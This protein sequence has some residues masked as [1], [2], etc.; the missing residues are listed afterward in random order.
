MFAD[1]ISLSRILLAYPLYQAF[2]LNHSFTAWCLMV[3]MIISDLIDGEVSRQYGASTYGKWLDPIADAVAMLAAVMGL[4]HL[5]V[6]SIGWLV[7]WILRYA[8]FAFF[9]LWLAYTKQYYIDSGLWNKISIFV[10]VVFLYVC[11]QWGYFF[12][13]LA[14]LLIIVQLISMLEVVYRVYHLNQPSATQEKQP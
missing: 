3:W 13:P 14:L 9:A 5:G 2:V 10:F 8:Y 4:Y 11:W 7:F 1:V 6:I 12:T